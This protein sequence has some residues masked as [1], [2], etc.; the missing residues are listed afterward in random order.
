[1]CLLLSQPQYNQSCDEVAYCTFF[2]LLSYAKAISL[3]CAYVRFVMT[4]MMVC[5]STPNMRKVGDTQTL[6]TSGETKQMKLNH[7]VYLQKRRSSLFYNWI[8]K[9]CISLVVE[10]NP[11]HLLK[12][13]NWKTR[14]LNISIACCLRLLPH[15]TSEGNIEVLLFIIYLIAILTSCFADS[16]YKL[17]HK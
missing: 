12:Y 10:N 15:Y 1:M 17:I 8:K 16:D 3:R 5:S 4:S 6:H 13:Y 11:V 7:K 14:L 2:A 9:W